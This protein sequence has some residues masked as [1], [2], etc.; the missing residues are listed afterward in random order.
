MKLSCR[1]FALSTALLA[2]CAGTLPKATTTTTSQVLSAPSDSVL[3][4]RPRLRVSVHAP[5]TA[6]YHS[7]TLGIGGERVVFRLTNASM[8]AV[9]VDHLHAAFSATRE[10]VEFPCPDH[11]EVSAKMREVALLEP[12]QSSTFERSLDCTMPLPGLYHVRAYLHFGETE[13]AP[14]APRNLAGSFDVI[15]EGNDKRAQ[16]YPS[17]EGLY[18]MMTGTPLRGPATSDLA[19]TGYKV[20]IA[21]INAGSQPS[22]IGSFHFSYLVYRQN[23]PL[24]CSGESETFA[25]PAYLAVGR[26]HIVTSR[27]ACVLS[28]E[29]SYVVVGKLV[30][31]HEGGGIE[32]GRLHFDVTKDPARRDPLLFVPYP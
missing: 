15:L 24:P 31:E 30:I 22:R 5:A 9:A 16:P 11:V 27:V 17:H 10:G 29:G 26:V 21:L 32:I 23:D 8:E 2:S 4:V 18:A 12:G 3:E 19:R 28:T 13:G 7:P 20:A 14:R 1:V 6:P 25:G